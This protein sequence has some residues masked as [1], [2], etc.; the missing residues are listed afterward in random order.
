M[1][2]NGLERPLMFQKMFKLEI[3]LKIN[4]RL[5]ITK[6]KNKKKPY[7]GSNPCFPIIVSRLKQNGLIDGEAPN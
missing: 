4:L 5:R 2:W 3:K 7:V 6:K 1:R